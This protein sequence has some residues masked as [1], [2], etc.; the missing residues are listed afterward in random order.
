VGQGLAE[1]NKL[2]YNSHHLFIRLWNFETSEE[3]DTLKIH[4]DNLHFHINPKP[5][6]KVHTFLSNLN[7]MNFSII[8][9]L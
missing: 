5:T 1:A 4:L 6:Q 9:S 2:F 3:S 8:I 7:N